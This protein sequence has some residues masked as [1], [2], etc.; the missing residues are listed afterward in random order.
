MAKEHHEALQEVYSWLKQKYSDTPIPRFEANSRTLS[1]LHKL[2]QINQSRD[3]E[4]EHIVGELKVR[5]ENLSLEAQRLQ[6]VL[7]D[8]GISSID[9]QSMTLPAC[10]YALSS[11]AST[12]NLK[13]AQTSSYMIGMQ[14][15]KLQLE[16]VMQR[17]VAE[18]QVL[19]DVMNKTDHV[20][21]QLS[22]LRRVLEHLAE[23]AAVGR[24]TTSMRQAEIWY[25]RGKAAEYYDALSTAPST[26][27]IT[28]CGL[29]HGKL[30]ADAEQLH[31]LHSLTAQL[32]EI[33][34]SY[35]D[36]PADASLAHLKIE[37]ARNRLLALD[38]R[39]TNKLSG[40]I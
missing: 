32:R 18:R 12:L 6:G 36:L 35:T 39:L 23:R 25:L 13:D 1:I 10:L 20:V 14:D 30:V 28:K 19:T 7:H 37:Q 22:Q 4:C 33:L 29:H 27:D 8:V 24:H 2:A 15:I 21:Q 31:Q 9:A 5:S 11:L 38:E 34:N 16:L 17:R 26:D 3:Q 40:M